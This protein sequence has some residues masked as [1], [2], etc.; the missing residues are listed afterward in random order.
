MTIIRVQHGRSYLLK[1]TINDPKRIHF[2]AAALGTPQVIEAIF[3][4][5]RR[6][7]IGIIVSPTLAILV[8]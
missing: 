5:Y 2:A 1:K 8:M 3:S 4:M 7:M 6:M